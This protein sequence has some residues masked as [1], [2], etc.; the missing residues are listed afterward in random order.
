MKNVV[1]VVGETDQTDCLLAKLL[2]YF[3][4][5]VSRDSIVIMVL[6]LR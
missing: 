2:H 6:L 4:N 3:R 5:I 1:R